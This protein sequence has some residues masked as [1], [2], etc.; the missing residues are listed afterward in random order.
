MHKVKELLRGEDSRDRDAHTKDH[1]G[2][3][4]ANARKAELQHANTHKPELQHTT[5]PRAEPQHAYT[6]NA[7]P[8]HAETQPANN[9]PS[10]ES[11]SQGIY[12]SHGERTASKSSHG[13]HGH[14]QGA[15]TASGLET[16][17]QTEHQ[18]HAQ[19]LKGVVNLQHSEDID[20]TTQWAPTVTHETVKPQTHEIRQE[21]IHRD[22]HTHDVYHHIQ[23]VLETEI[24]PTRHFIRD[25]LDPAHTRLIEVL[26]KDL[27]PGKA[28][29]GRWYIGKRKEMEKPLRDLPAQRVGE[30]G[31]T[32]T[33]TPPQEHKR[34]H[35]H[36]HTQMECE[37]SCS[38]TFPPPAAKLTHAK[39]VKETQ[40]TEPD[41]SQRT[42]SVIVHPARLEDMSS[43]RGPVLEMH[44]RG[45]GE[46]R[47]VEERLCVWGEG[48]RR[49][50]GDKALSKKMEGS[51]LEGAS[52]QEFGSVALRRRRTSS[53]SSL[54]RAVCSVEVDEAGL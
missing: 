11:S 18:Q 52:L 54:R 8:Q 22:I 13:S 17:S 46:E 35:E 53:P 34:E 3:H 16:D 39:L 37:T 1:A 14:S 44:F 25:P 28:H 2:S 50:D 5:H 40:S 32:K 7:G 20:R 48:N 31:D 29:S 15:R 45:T 49:N 23:P 27:P 12:Q 51:E 41:G 36:T 43:Y 24:L 4:L 47:R 30:G 42:H 6:E 21:H 10:S 38:T 26:E 19:N 9:C 33:L